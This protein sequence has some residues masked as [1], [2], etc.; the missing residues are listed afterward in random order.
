MTQKHRQDIEFDLRKL[1][2][3]M[4]R[5]LLWIILCGVIAAVIVAAAEIWLVNPV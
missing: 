4:W 3:A 1:L 2:T 5:K